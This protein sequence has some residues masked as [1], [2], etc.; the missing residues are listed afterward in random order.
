MP[1]KLI[2][3]VSLPVA[4]IF[5]VPIY[6]YAIAHEELANKNMEGYYSCCGKSICRGCE[7]SFNNSGNTRKCP[8]CNS[9]RADITDEENVEDLMKRLVEELMM[10]VEAN[11]P[12]S[13]S[14][15]GNHYHHG[16]RG[17][18]QDHAKA[19]EL[20]VRAANLGCS[21]AHSHLAGVYHEGGNMKKAKFHY[22]AAAMAGHEVAR[23]YLGCMEANSDNMERAMK[24]FTIGASAGDHKAMHELITF[25]KQ[26]HVSRESID[27]TLEAYNNSCAEVRSEA[28][29]AYIRVL[30]GNE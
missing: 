26:G 27:S 7:H 1:E 18:Q 20:Y 19:I 8:F 24:H 17:F 13:I 21:K 3:C 28:R 16:L 9:D 4:T 11:D 22:E 25:F 30:M 2:C 15:L 10:R 12:I 5:S 6:D 14:V 23:H 29:D